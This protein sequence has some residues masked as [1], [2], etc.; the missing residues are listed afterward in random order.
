VAKRLS[1]LLGLILII[2]AGFLIKGG[3]IRHKP[4]VLTAQSSPTT[5]PKKHFDYRIVFI[6]DSM[7]EYLGNF[8]QLEPDLDRY[9][10]GK[11]FLLLNYG[12]SST[13]ILEAFD[14]VDHDTNHNNRVYEAVDKIP[15]DLVIIESFG[16]NPL[17][18]FP[19]Q[20]GL[21]KQTEALDKI[22]ASLTKSH[23][24][25]SIVFMVT[26]APSR[27]RYGEGA[28]VLST[29]ERQKWAD[30]RIAYMKNHMNYAKSHNIPLIN[31]YQDSLTK[32]GTANTDY[33]NQSDFI[34]P[35]PTGI[36][37]I[38]QKI[39]DFIHKN[40]LIKR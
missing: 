12:Y 19:L 26:I 11:K 24:K 36:I 31:V 1:L 23:P 8:D 3:F 15:F 13:N 28:V 9:Y 16:N 6:G 14:R 27:D 39:A 18:Q 33:L 7:T 34:H 30:E 29:S 4:S 2:L 35:S 37:F 5:I 20:E 32:Q 17:S 40:N 38:S 25:S 22:V 10:P 21:A